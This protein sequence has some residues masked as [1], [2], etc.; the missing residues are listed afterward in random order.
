[1]YTLKRTAGFLVFFFFMNICLAQKSTVD[2]PGT[3]TLRFTSSINKHDYVLHISLPGSYSDSTKKYPVVYV[4]DGQWNFPYMVGINGGLFYDGLV[5]ELIIVGITWPN[6]FE[7]NRTRDFSPTISSNFPN[8]GGAPQFLQVLKKEIVARINKTYHTDPNNNCLVGGS[9][10]ALFTLYALFH[11]PTLFKGYV[12]GSPNIDYDN[13]VTFAFEK[14]FAQK[15]KTLHVR[16]LISD[17]EYE[18]Q[19]GYSEQLSRFVSQLKASNYKGLEIER[20]VVEKMGHASEGPYA[21]SRGLQFVYG[22]PE[23]LLDTLVLDQYTGNYQAMNEHFTITRIGDH[24]YVIEK[25]TKIKIYTKDSE[26]FYAKGFPGSAQF[27][28]DSNGK[29]TEYVVTIGNDKLVAKKID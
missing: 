13:E 28:K 23:I 20:L 27:T 21:H 19:T 1:M 9:F 11:E 12:V 22:I 14:T 17:G 10:S 18:E 8:A 25:N 24:L 4:L 6:D 2:L 29:V 5:P 15:N 7:G 3:S 26:H 16:V